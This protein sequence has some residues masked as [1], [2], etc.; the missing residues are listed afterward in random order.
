MVISVMSQLPSGHA[1]ILFCFGFFCLLVLFPV[2]FWCLTLF[3][4]Q[5]PP[6]PCLFSRQ[7]DCPPL[8]D[9]LHLCLGIPSSLV[10][11]LCMLSDFCANL[12]LSPHS[13][14][15][16]I[17][18]PDRLSNVWPCFSI[19]TFCLCPFVHV[20]SADWSPVHPTWFKFC[21]FLN[22]ICLELCTLVRVYCV[23]TC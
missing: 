20:C 18:P 19:L 16:S 9:V 23:R 10:S 4:F 6:C 3:S 13:K 15:S 8:P 14:H 5:I 17:S 21:A 12:S 1:F 22:L 11:V 7:C 2:L